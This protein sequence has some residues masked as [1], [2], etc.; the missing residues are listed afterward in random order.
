[1]TK[2]LRSL[3][4]GFIV[5]LLT[6][7][8]VAVAASQTL[9]VS[10][11]NIKIVVDGTEIIPT[12]AGGNKVEPFISNGTTYL[13]VRA[14]ANALG[15]DVYWDGPNYTVY[16]GS[17]NGTLEYPSLKLGD[18]TNIGYNFRSSGDLTDNYGNRYSVAQMLYSYGNGEFASLLNMKYS[19]F[20]G[21]VYVPTG[22]SSSSTASF[23]IEADGKSIYTSPE[24][25]KTSQP[26]QIDINITGCND[27]KIKLSTGSDGRVIRFGD[28]GFYQ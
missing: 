11:N 2:R 10:Y 22:Y 25:T 13:P 20:K 23:I 3:I 26:I 28:C 21:T 14:V 27:F 1:M 18:A 8:G 17:M 16:L 4:A 7:G 19:R 9:P 6:A 5:G 12:D 24:M 15:K